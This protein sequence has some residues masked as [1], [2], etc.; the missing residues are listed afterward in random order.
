M[1]RPC[2][3][4]PVQDGTANAGRMAPPASTRPN[5]IEKRACHFEQIIQNRLKRPVLLPARLTVSN[6]VL[7]NERR[8]DRAGSEI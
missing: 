2:T 8:Q 1:F 7:K 5:G 4:A 3:E 6:M